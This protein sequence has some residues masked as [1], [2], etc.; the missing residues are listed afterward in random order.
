MD[1]D[2]I[3]RRFGMRR[4]D[5]AKALSA[6]AADARAALP[7]L[8][9]ERLI[10]RT[11]LDMLRRTLLP[12]ALSGDIQAARLLVRIHQAR[13]MLL[14]LLDEMPVLDTDSAEE[15]NELDRI[16]A[17]RSARRASSA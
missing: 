3:A 8:E 17:R 9:G 14:G 10:E 12:A 1:I 2:A 4:A 6:D 7:D 11:H 5:A 16:R 13:A 15:V